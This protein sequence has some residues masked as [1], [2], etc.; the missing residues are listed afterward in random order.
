MLRIILEIQIKTSEILQAKEAYDVC[1]L[2]SDSA[3]LIRS[4]QLFKMLYRVICIPTLNFR[5]RNLMYNKSYET[6]S[7]FPSP[8]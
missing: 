5:Q 4:L 8:S 7:T 1:L 2:V 3:Y 6:L